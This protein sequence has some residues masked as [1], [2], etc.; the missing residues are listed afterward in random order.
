M[1]LEIWI[2]FS[3]PADRTCYRVLGNLT[4]N[5][6]K[7]EKKTYSGY[8]HKKINSTYRHIKYLY[9]TGRN[10]SCSKGSSYSEQSRSEHRFPRHSST[11]CSESRHIIPNL[12]RLRPRKWFLLKK[13]RVK[14]IHRWKNII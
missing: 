4:T 2:Y 13:G 9:P 6:T 10:E 7:L 14:K 1:I 8:P 11:Y 5:A 3:Q 12:N